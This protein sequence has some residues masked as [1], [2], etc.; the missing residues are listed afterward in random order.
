MGWLGI[1]HHHPL[2]GGVLHL[3]SEA[4]G[5]LRNT[6]AFQS[7]HELFFNNIQLFLDKA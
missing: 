7:E 2:G 1:Y 5:F 4:R 3:G 6:Y